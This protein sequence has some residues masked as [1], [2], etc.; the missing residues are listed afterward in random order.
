MVKP[1]KE[2]AYTVTL[3]H[4]DT[5]VVYPV[6]AGLAVTAYDTA[7]R[8]GGVLHFT[9]PDSKDDPER[10][11]LFPSMFA[12]TGLD[13]FL[14]ELF[15]SGASRKSLIIK[16]AGGAA[17]FVGKVGANKKN[18]LAAKRLLWKHNL[19]VAGESTGGTVGIHLKLEMATG[20]VTVKSSGG[21]L[22]L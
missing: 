8:V 2:A 12:D 13:A 10:A 16:L 19:V 6:C 1:V 14:W 9:Q 4:E 20:D 22:T 17:M 7:S 18:V 11:K 3:D 5:L 21:V 15:K